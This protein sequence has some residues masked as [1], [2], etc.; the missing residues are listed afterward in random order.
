MDTGDSKVDKYCP[1]ETFSKMQATSCFA[2]N[3]SKWKM[4]TKTYNVRHV[5]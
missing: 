5:K 2:V 4:E 1:R 3:I